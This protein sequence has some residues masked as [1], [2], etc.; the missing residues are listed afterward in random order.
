M[1]HRSARLGMGIN[2]QTFRLC[3][4]E[5]SHSVADRKGAHK[6]VLEKFRNLHERSLLLVGCDYSQGKC[7]VFLF[8]INSI[9]FFCTHINSRLQ[10]GLF[11]FLRWKITGCCILWYLHGD[12]VTSIFTSKSCASVQYILWEKKEKKNSDFPVMSVRHFPWGRNALTAN[13]N[14]S[15]VT[16]TWPFG[17]TYFT[18]VINMETTWVHPNKQAPT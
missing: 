3:T 8:E 11:V 7:L 13:T 15:S 18:P 5:A 1:S 12:T 9:C 2:E 16:L 6:Y 14:Y 10:V 4:L 17:T